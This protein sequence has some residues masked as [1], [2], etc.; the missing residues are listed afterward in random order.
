MARAALVVVY[1]DRQRLAE[2][3]QALQQ[4]F[5]A[6]YQIL[7]AATPAAILDTLGRVLV[8]PPTDQLAQ[9]LGVQTQ[10]T[11][12]HYDAAVIGAGPAGLAAPPL[13]PP[14]GCARCSWS[15]R[16]SAAKQPPRR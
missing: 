6:D 7:P 9:A 3:E 14:K 8:D 10:P 5:G 15:V 2:L 13:P 4:R 1:D 12:G 11:L 16:R